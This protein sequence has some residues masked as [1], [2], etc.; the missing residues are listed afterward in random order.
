MV[1][2]RKV[3][4]LVAVGALSSA[5]V[6]G[7]ITGEEDLT[8]EVGSTAAPLIAAA[9]GNAIPDQYIVVFKDKVGVE[10]V[11]AAI[12]RISFASS[13]SRV[14]HQ[15]SVIPGFSARLAPEDV[16]ALR[17]DQDVAFVEQDQMM[18]A[19]ATK[20]ASGQLDLDRHDRLPRRGRQRLQRQRL[21]RQ[22]R[23]RVRR[24]HRHPRHAPGVRQP[25]QHRS[26]FHRHQRRPRH[27][28][29]QRARLARL[30]R[31]RP[32][33][34]SDWRAPPP[35]SRSACSAAPVRAATRASSPA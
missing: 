14:E 9:A 2:V 7:C 25:G 29:L 22:R 11:G 6:V 17:R 32:A 15:Y 1:Q 35:S 8:E 24:R 10:G 20:P 21:Q 3:F 16:E 23:A 28:G 18:F 33:P 12:D 13:V 31:R 4:R 5:L 26:R 19:T 30:V 27:H 34:R